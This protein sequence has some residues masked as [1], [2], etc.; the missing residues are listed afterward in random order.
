MNTLEN[1]KPFSLS[2]A[3][4]AC[5]GLK[6]SQRDDT[7]GQGFLHLRILIAWQQVERLSPAADPYH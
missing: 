6:C 1:L 4:D 5:M 2:A 7:A 3:A